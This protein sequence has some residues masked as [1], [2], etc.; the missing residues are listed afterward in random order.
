MI[1][2]KIDSGLN[3][4]SKRIALV[5]LGWFASSAYHGIY[6]LDRKAAVLEHVQQVDI[7]KL[8]AA[9][10]CE[11]KRADKTAAVAGQAITSADVDAVPT[12]HYKDIPQD[13]C[14]RPAA[15]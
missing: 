15:K 11:G 14:P 3:T 13:N 12:P 6:T 9:A 8:K 10:N 7:P 2:E 4:W 1:A 5:L